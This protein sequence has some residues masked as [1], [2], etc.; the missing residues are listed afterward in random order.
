M[1]TCCN[2]E[3][4]T[5]FCPQCGKKLRTNEPPLRALVRQCFNNAQSL[6]TKA[7]NL[8]RNN[9]YPKAMATAERSS[10]RWKKW[11]EELEK[12]LEIT[13]CPKLVEGK[14]K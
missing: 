6:A 1:A 5:P 9:L 13:G 12:L 8:R 7:T 14:S 3:V 4:T 11:G 10:A 2:A